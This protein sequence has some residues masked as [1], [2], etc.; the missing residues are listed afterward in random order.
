[1]HP[2]EGPEIPVLNLTR[3][4]QSAVPVAKCLQVNTY[5]YVVYMCIYKY[6]CVQYIY[7]YMSPDSGS[8][9]APP[10]WYGPPS[11]RSREHGTVDT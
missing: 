2:V 11:S 4:L 3:V 7:K 1:M 10:Q 8:L 6:V 9:Q 5:I